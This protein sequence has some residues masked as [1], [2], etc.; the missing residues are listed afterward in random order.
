MWGHIWAFLKFRLNLVIRTSFGR[1][2]PPGAIS[3]R[4]AESAP[5]R[6]WERN[7]TPVQIGLT[8]FH[9]GFAICDLTWG[10]GEGGAIMALSA[11]KQVMT[12]ADLRS[13]VIVEKQHEHFFD[14]GLWQN[15][16]SNFLLF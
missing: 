12:I 9:K 2:G 14:F 7:V 6:V 10:E 8:L 5:P 13:L 15:D 16:L 4:W 3:S 11:R 1:N